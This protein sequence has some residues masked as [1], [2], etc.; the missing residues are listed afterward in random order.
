VRSRRECGWGLLTPGRRPQESLLR[1]LLLLM[2]LLLLLLLLL[3]SARRP[4]EFQKK[5]AR[6]LRF[7]HKGATRFLA[8]TYEPADTAH[9]ARFMGS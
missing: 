2:L 3:T 4:Q 1:L 9:V 8:A 7:V 6:F 5:A